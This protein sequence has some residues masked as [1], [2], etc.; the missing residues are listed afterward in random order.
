MPDQGE[1]C[2]FEDGGALFAFSYLKEESGVYFFESAML[3]AQ[4]PDG[5]M[6]G[7]QFAYIPGDGFVFQNISLDGDLFLMASGKKPFDVSSY[8]VLGNHFCE[9]QYRPILDD[10]PGTTFRDIVDP[11]SLAS[12]S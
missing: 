3:P 11:A 12:M 6:E 5:H 1:L 7:G 8:R 2:A 10:I 9:G 4:A